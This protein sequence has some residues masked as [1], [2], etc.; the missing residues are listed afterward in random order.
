MDENPFN[1]LNYFRLRQMDRDGGGTYSPVRSTFFEMEES[2]VFIYP[3]PFSNQLQVQVKGDI[4]G[5]TINIYDAF[6]RKAYGSENP[7]TLLDLRQLPA[8][9][10]YLEIKNG[11]YVQRQ[12][13][14][15][16]E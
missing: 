3:N 14:V 11:N 15:K 2:S 5:Y 4:D 1:G 7:K 9:S 13:I 8:G 10:Y 16:Q 12:T 6:G